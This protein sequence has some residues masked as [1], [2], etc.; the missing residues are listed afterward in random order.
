MHSRTL[1]RGSWSLAEGDSD[2]SDL[3]RVDGAMEGAAEPGERGSRGRRVWWAEWGLQQ[4]SGLASL[5][6]GPTVEGWGKACRNI[7]GKALMQR[8]CYTDKELDG[9]PGGGQRGW[10]G[11]SEG[12]V[13]GGDKPWLLPL[14]WAQSSFIHVL[15]FR[16]RRCLPSV[17]EA[18]HG[19]EGQKRTAWHPGCSGIYYV[20]L[21]S[22]GRTAAA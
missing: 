11:R 1:A 13:V 7:Y 12:R 5:K 20:I 9:G 2:N 8:Y 16:R 6:R 15:P 22:I 3:R 21:K 19:A 10:N 18:G 17:K 4:E 14:Y